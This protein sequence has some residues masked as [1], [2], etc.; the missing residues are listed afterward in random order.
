MNTHYKELIEKSSLFQHVKTETVE[1]AIY[2]GIL[3]TMEE[4]EYFFLQGDESTHAYVL[5]SGRVK[6]V[7]VTPNGQQITLRIMTSGQT[8]GGIALLSPPKGYPATAQAMEDSIAISWNT[9]QLRKWA[10]NDSTLSFNTMQIMHGYIMDLQERQAGLTSERVEQ[11]IAR[12]LLKLAAQSG[13]KVDE[14]VL[15]NMKLTRQDIAEMSGTTLFTVSRTLTE[16]ER[17]GLL[18]IGRERVMICNPHGL[19]Q[20]ADDLAHP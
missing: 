11:R 10:S 4:G 3:R 14:G 5:L 1:H 15:I 9:N 18:K 16:W 12:S 19:V 20:I 17:A 8:Y 6:L 13:K 2:E 7:Q